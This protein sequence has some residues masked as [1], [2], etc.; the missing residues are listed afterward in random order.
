MIHLIRSWLA[1]AAATSARAFDFN[2]LDMHLVVGRTA[3][4][5]ERTTA[6]MYGL[7]SKSALKV[8]SLSLKFGNL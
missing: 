3:A 5:A 7:C 1:F 2:V 4:Y 6:M 8:I